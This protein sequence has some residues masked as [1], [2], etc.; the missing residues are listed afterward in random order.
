MNKVIFTPLFILCLSLIGCP[1]IL[2]QPEP[3][4]NNLETK[5]LEDG[6]YVVTKTANDKASLL[7]LKPTQRIITY[8]K[9]FYDEEDDKYLLI[10]TDDFVPLS[11]KEKPT[12]EHKKDKTQN[13]Y[14][15]LNDVA[16]TK[17]EQFTTLNL[18]KSTGIVVNGEAY[19]K[20]KIKSVITGGKLQIT[21]CTENACRVLYDQ[22]DDNVIGLPSDKDWAN[23]QRFEK[24]NK[25]IDM[26]KDNENR[27]V[28]MGNSITEGWLQE[29]LTLFN[30]PNHINRGVSGQT[31]P[32]MLVRF[33]PDVIDLKP[34][35]V[36]ILA[37]I[38]D[39]AGN[40]GPMTLEATFNNIKSMAELAAANE[41]Q[42]ILSSVLPAYD[43]PW[44]PG[45][46]P[47]GKV[48][49][50]NEM[51]KAYCEEKGFIYLDYHTQMADDRNGLPENL[52]YD[53]VHPTLEGY[54]VMEKI[55]TS[56]LE[57]LD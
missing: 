1:P 30:N 12:T 55:L 21:Q 48:L 13:F 27:I 41:I 34:K 7:P 11:L 2:S 20:H 45:L 33:R 22:F 38:N 25:A 44:N 32:Q 5:I 54:H 49:K 16:K 46:N 57:K 39:I 3:A 36:V 9:D 26:S 10:E 43:F 53:E 31:T 18:Y 52:S 42:V 24:Q 50:I 37:G 14:L 23:L 56:A 35:A 15:T 51:M 4:I 19:T 29:G 28:F 40:T 47:S 8:N 6:F 17:L